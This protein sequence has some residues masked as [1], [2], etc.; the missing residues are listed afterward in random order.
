MKLD[1]LL[2]LISTSLFG[3]IQKKEYILDED[4]KIIMQ[5]EFEKKLGEYVDK[6]TKYSYVIINTD[7][8]ITAKLVTRI[9]TGNISKAKRDDLAAHLGKT[10]GKK[11]SS[12]QTLLVYFFYP[13]YDKSSGMMNE[14]C[15]RNYVNNNKIKRLSKE[16]EISTCNIHC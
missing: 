7:S 16:K 8:T 9:S 13:D 2:F 5:S 1:L 11:V 15:I 10:T 6:A 14:L 12:N 4:D 3:Q